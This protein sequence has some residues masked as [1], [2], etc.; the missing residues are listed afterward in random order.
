VNFFKIALPTT[1]T[2][3]NSA[4]VRLVASRLEWSRTTL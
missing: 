1:P 4:H 3:S 2:D